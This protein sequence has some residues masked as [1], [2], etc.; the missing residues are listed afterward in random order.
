MASLLAGL[1]GLR[2]PTATSCVGSFI[3]SSFHETVLMEDE[4]E[5]LCHPTFSSLATTCF[6]D[7]VKALGPIK[8][9]ARTLL[10][11]ASKALARG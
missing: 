10:I 6:V 4:N 5:I 2:Q 1:T 9:G 3:S 11:L 7:T 8:V